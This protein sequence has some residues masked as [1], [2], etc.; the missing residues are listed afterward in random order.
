MVVHGEAFSHIL[1][2][3][4]ANVRLDP[5]SLL[6]ADGLYA[7]WLT[8]AHQILPSTISIATTS[9]SGRSDRRMELHIP[10]RTELDL[11]GSAVSIAI[12]ATL[13]DMAP[14][15]EYCLEDLPRQTAA[16]AHTMFC[17]SYRATLAHLE[18]PPIPLKS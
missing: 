6:P 2:F 8:T 5:D 13:R 12:V 9:T 15:D 1:G 10:R 17:M 11:Y 16:G 14:L 4:T 7:G 18:E 3:A